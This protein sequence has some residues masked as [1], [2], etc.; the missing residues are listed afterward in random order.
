MFVILNI[1]L[2]PND[3]KIGLSRE[4]YLN[5]VQKARGL[6]TNIKTVTSPTNCQTKYCG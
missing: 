2:S 4:K 3:M 1:N 5:G 6:Y